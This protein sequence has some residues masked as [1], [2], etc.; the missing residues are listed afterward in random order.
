[1]AFGNTTDR[2]VD[3]HELSTLVPYSQTH[4]GR[5]ESQGAFPGRIRLG[6]NRVGWSLTEVLAWMDEK[7]RARLGDTDGAQLYK[8]KQ[9]QI[10]GS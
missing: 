1:M 7:K 5:L 2:I 3:R 4:I 9:S 10:K 6:A 8:S